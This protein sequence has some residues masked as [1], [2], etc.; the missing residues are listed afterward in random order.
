M[1]GNILC[2]LT[3]DALSLCS[4]ETH[5]CL[6]VTLGCSCTGIMSRMM[7][8][9]CV[10]KETA[11]NS[12]W[13]MLVQHMNQNQ[14]FHCPDLVTYQECC[15]LNQSIIWWLHTRFCQISENE[16]KPLIKAVPWHFIPAKI[17]LTKNRDAWSWSGCSSVWWHVV[18]MF[19]KASFVWSAVTL[20]I[21][22]LWENSTLISCSVPPIKKI[23]HYWVISQ[24]VDTESWPYTTTRLTQCNP[25][26][27]FVKTLVSTQY[28]QTFLHGLYLH[29]QKCP[30][31]VRGSLVF[32]CIL[33]LPPEL[34]VIVASCFLLNNLF[35]LSAVLAPSL[36]ESII[37][38]KSLVKE[39]SHLII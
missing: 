11:W 31:C 5:S 29:W 4:L 32:L 17:P 8:C 23:I 34:P 27:Y 15:R 1:K 26:T 19:M 25:F 18:A 3:W 30:E 24:Q 33:Q 21:A 37:N 36:L 2:Q 28:C 20:Q 22:K 13:L 35:M 14:I 10:L 6:F 16:V 9:S 39:F 12:Y 38:R 7:T